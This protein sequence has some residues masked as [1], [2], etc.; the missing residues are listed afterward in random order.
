MSNEHDHHA[1]ADRRR[2]VV[3][4]VITV[5]F[6]GVEVVGAALTGSLALLGDA[7]HMLSDALALGVAIVAS[8]VAARPATDR[9]TFGFRRAEVFGALVNG[10]LLALIA[11][12]VAVE[13]V[14]RLV[15]GDAH[16]A[17]GGMLAVAIAGLV[18]NVVAALVLRGGVNRSIN[19]RAAYL[20]VLGDTLG[21]IAAIVASVVILTTG[22]GAADA[23][24]S[25]VIAALILPRA[26]M[27][28]RDVVHV[29][30]DA[31]P[32]GTDVEQIRAHILGTAGVVGV[33]DVHVWQITS[34]AP[35]FTAHVVVQPAILVKGYA[36]DLLDRLGSCLTEHFDVAHS[37]FQ[38]EV[39][40]HAEHEAH[41]HR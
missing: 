8:V 26:V 28:L 12:G 22:F 39:A 40:E 16:V 35:V 37:T 32:R 34:G 21:S 5:A 19:L 1:G 10:A 27:L 18:A 4:L 31:A 33:H 7:G 41:V 24:A 36:D 30:S 38:I 2:L 25:L 13:A 29:L 17:S 9:A 11:I 14:A 23:I 20:D 6:L 3:A 15:Q